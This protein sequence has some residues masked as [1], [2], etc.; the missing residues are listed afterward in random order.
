MLARAA[1][2]A[3]APE[4]LTLTHKGPAIQKQIRGRK[5]DIMVKALRKAFTDVEVKIEHEKSFC[6][7]KLAFIPR[8][9][10]SRAPIKL[11]LFYFYKPAPA[12]MAKVDESK[13]LSVVAMNTSG[14]F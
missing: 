4:K 5:R 11:K 3:L 13:R 7:K 14:I 9:K 10:N 1:G 8:E 6:Y 2:E 12:V